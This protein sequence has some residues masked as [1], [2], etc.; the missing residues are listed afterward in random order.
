MGHQLE[1]VK[2]VVKSWSVAL[3][4]FAAIV[5]LWITVSEESGR[6]V[7]QAVSWTIA[8]ITLYFA[9]Y[10]AWLEKRNQV[11]RYKQLLLDEYEDDVSRVK[12]EK[13]PRG[14]F[15]SSG[16]EEAFYLQLISGDHDLILEAVRRWRA[17]KAK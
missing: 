1:F 15:A 16:E 5:L 17:H 11:E 4:G 6:R 8:F 2:A 10:L 14:E 13:I 9:V 7:P 3:G 12:S